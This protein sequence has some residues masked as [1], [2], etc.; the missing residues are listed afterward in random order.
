MNGPSAD[1]QL[2]GGLT[3]AETALDQGADG[4]AAGVAGLALAA[5]ELVVGVGVCAAFRHNRERMEWHWEG[6]EM[7]GK[8]K[9]WKRKEWKGKERKGK[10]R[11]GKCKQSS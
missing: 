8:Q 7:N 10:E 5:R 3:A 9:E 11:K 6:K 2:V 1:W 4:R